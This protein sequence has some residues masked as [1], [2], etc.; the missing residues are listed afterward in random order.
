MER[1]SGAFIIKFE[2]ISH[3]FVVFLLLTFCKKMFV[4]EHCLV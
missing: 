3:I 1:H 4:G 2:H